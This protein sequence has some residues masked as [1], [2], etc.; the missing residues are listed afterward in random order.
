[1]SSFLLSIF[2]VSFLIYF[3]HMSTIFGLQ[4]K[5]S[6]IFVVNLFSCVRSKCPENITLL[7]LVVSDNFSL[8]KRI[9]LLLPFIYPLFTFLC[10]KVFLQTSF[11]SNASISPFLAKDKHSAA[12]RHSDLMT[13]LY[14]LIFDF[15]GRECF[16]LFFFFLNRKVGW[17]TLCQTSVFID[18]KK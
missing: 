13:L 17:A 5:C 14:C 15:V 4:L 11:F 1:M 12:Y 18:K 7:L 10:S 16:H 8:F 2:S 3:M 6:N 9:S